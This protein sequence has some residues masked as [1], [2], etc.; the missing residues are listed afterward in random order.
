MS[1]LPD[2]ANQSI[3]NGT[4]APRA[5]RRATKHRFVLAA[6]VLAAVVA[7]C[8]SGD[9][10]GR[11]ASGAASAMPSSGPGSSG[12]T[13]KPAQVTVSG[14]GDILLHSPLWREASAIATRAG[15]SGFDF[16]PMFAPVKQAISSADVAICHQETPISATNDDLSRP[17][18]LVF[19]VPTQIAGSLKRAGFEGCDTSS[20]HT[21]D[22]GVPGI[23]ATRKVLGAAGLKVAG[24]TGSPGELGM[25]ALYD[26][27]GVT[28]AN[29]AYTYTLPNSAGPNTVVPAS[30]PWLKPYLWPAA[31]AKGIIANAQAAKAAGADLVVVNIHWGTEGVQQPTAD[32]VSLAQELAASPAVDAIFGTHAHVVQ[33]CVKMNGKFVFYGLGNFISNQGPG[34]GPQNESNRDG[35]LA[36]IT[37]TRAGTGQWAQQASYQPTYVDTAAQHTIRLATPASNPASWKRTQQAMNAQGSCPALAGK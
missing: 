11:A 23:V 6:A 16:D 14:S 17:G 15:K 22:Q 8:S 25:P 29:I 2:L 24:P 32:Q 18:S 13:G 7:G 20:N 9:G 35:V 31:G 3:P 34:R 5:P 4:P 21:L 12:F 37:F 1:H 28:V 27:R 19:N 26:V 30:V 10:G 33:P 36:Q